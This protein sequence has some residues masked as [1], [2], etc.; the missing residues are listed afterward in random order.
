MA[1]KHRIASHA[2]TSD[3]IPADGSSVVPTLVQLL[4][5]SPFS[6]R[7][8]RGPYSY[9]PQALIDAFALN[10]KPLHIDYEHQSI[11]A[12]AKTAP[13]PAAGWI[14]Q[15]LWLEDSLWAEVEW[16][17]RA[18]AMIAA[19]EY[20]YL[21]PVFTF[22]T[23]TGEIIALRGAGLTNDP[24]L[25]LQSLN[26]QNADRYT[27]GNLTP[28]E[29]EMLEKILEALGVAADADEAT[30]LA[31]VAAMKAAADKAAAVAAELGADADADVPAI[32]EAAQSRF[33]TDLST[34]VARDELE[35]MKQRAETAE[36][37]LAALKEA[38]HK[39]EVED[40]VGAAITAGKFTPAQSTWLVEAANSMGL[41]KFK[42]FV[43]AS[44]VLSI[45]QN[46]QLPAVD[47]AEKSTLTE[48]QRQMIA[49][50]GISAEDFMK[51]RNSKAAN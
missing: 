35:A 40:V 3:L 26:S 30:V 28:H 41:D 46:T 13:T 8:G 37:E 49:I 25:H 16:T 22:N 33:A 14:N 45:A 17:E 21:S 12:D 50:A 42:Q 36:A 32:V 9:D 20:R 23:K 47:D 2:F 5:A 43:E 4:P 1:R 19:R 11:G 24:N 27:D 38:A 48:E 44:P 6:G 39:K 31:A 10:G 51:A 18:A 29:E 7:D 34:Y 15:L